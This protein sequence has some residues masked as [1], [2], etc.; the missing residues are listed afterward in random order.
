MCIKWNKNKNENVIMV[1]DKLKRCKTWILCSPNLP[2]ITSP[3]AQQLI[4]G[5]NSSGV[6]NVG[7]I[8]IGVTL[9]PN[10]T[11]SLA[12]VS[13][14]HLQVSGGNQVGQQSSPQAPTYVNL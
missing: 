10:S 9:M 4:G 2:A 3:T 5:I 12:S 7:S 8:G 11:A 14:S 13:G 1:I 6:G